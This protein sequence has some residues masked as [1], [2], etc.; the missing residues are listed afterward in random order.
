MPVTEWVVIIVGILFVLVVSKRGYN[1]RCALAK[2]Q[3]L[4]G[5]QDVVRVRSS[6]DEHEEVCHTFLGNP[7]PLPNRLSVRVYLEGR[8]AFSNFVPQTFA[9]GR[10]TEL[11][12]LSTSPYRLKMGSTFFSSVFNMI[13]EYL[14]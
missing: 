11:V 13:P 3:P 9:S 1:T 4:G 7:S 8:P 12:R 6:R 10:K 2:S 14:I 5:C